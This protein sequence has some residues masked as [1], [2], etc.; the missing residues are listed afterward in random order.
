MLKYLV[1]ILLFSQVVFADIQIK[2]FPQMCGT[3]IEMENFLT[4]KNY[5]KYAIAVAKRDGLP[6]GDPIYFIIFYKHDY[7]K[8]IV[9]V[10]YVIGIDEM[11]ASFISYD[12]TS[13]EEFNVDS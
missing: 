1:G 8:S 6:T 11:C 4:E 3:V 10:Q 7:Y 5:V 13:F 12:Y 2:M 9:P